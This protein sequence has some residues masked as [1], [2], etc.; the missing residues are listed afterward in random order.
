MPYY[1]Y[2]AR[3]DDGRA[4]TGILTADGPGDLETGLRDSGLYLITSHR[5][6][7]PRFMSQRLSRKELI[8]FTGQL[9]SIAGSGIPLIEGLEDI[10]GESDRLASRATV[11]SIIGDLRRGKSLSAALEE[12]PTAFGSL[13]VNTVR[14]GEEM[15]SLESVL[16]RLVSY[17][18]WEEEVSSRIK[19][20]ATYPV[21]V[22]IVLTGVIGI[23]VG[24]I[25]PRF[26][27]IFARKGFPLPLPTRI[28]LE[29]SGFL[30]GNWPL[31]AAAAIGIVVA[32]RLLGATGTGRHAYDWT[33]LNLPVLGGLMRKLALTRFAHTMATT[34]GSGVDI[35]TAIDLAGRSTGNSLFAGA[36]R[37]AV[38]SLR[39]GKT[40][41]ASLKGTGLFPALFLRMVAVGETTGALAGM[42]EKASRAYDREVRPAVARIMTA[43]EALVT[44]VMGVAVAT[45][46]LSI[47]LPLYRM[48]MLIRR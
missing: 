33:K 30:R 37:E 25:L 31:V 19:Q 38:G 34:V 48:L 14:A 4:V 13:Y 7:R 2:K 45:V 6:A 9:A 3:D 24:F 17:L 47:F 44:I 28:L 22:G 29:T 16:D 21:I 40:V 41:A 1:K 23:L 46:A 15:G 26:A 35:I 39:D 42:L 12:S 18:E 27:S 32:A 43:F 5:V 10:R 8:A 20:A 11:E 36:G